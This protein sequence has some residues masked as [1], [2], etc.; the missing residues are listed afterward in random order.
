[1]RASIRFTDD[2]HGVRLGFIERQSTGWWM[3]WSTAGA[4][5]PRAFLG[6]AR[7]PRDDARIVRDR[8]RR[9]MSGRTVR[10]RFERP[11]TVL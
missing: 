7:R 6:A 4:D 11:H 1:M 8:W 2:P 3:S 5:H 10:L 9:C